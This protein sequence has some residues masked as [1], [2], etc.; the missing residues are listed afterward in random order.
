MNRRHFMTL[1]SAAAATA[2]AATDAKLHIATNTY[3]WGTFAKRDSHAFPLHTDASLAAIASTGILG[4][5]PSVGT[6]VEFDGLGARLKAHGLEMRSLYVNSTLHDDAQAAQS[7]ENALAIARKA[8]ELGCRIIVTNPSPIK[9][10]G[11]ENKS[12]EQ[13]ITQAAALDQLGA[14]L[15]KLGM[16]LAYH[17]HD[18][19]LRNGGR[20]FHHMLTATNPENVKFCL[21]AHWVFRGCGDSQVALFDSLEHYG[22]RIVELHL[23]QSSGGVWTE[24]FTGKGDID[25]GRLVGWLRKHGIKPHLVLEQAVENGSLHTMDAVAAHK[26]GAEHVGKLFAEL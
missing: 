23:R 14:E 22:S 15:K 13:L 18:I 19:E 21:D 9:W 7:I 20:E 6:A 8:G 2:R 5:E 17:N 16:A 10:G 25:Y 3:P 24:V 11:P 26:Q 1:A 4:Y 12:D